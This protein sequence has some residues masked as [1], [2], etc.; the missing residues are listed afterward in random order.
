MQEQSSTTGSYDSTNPSSSQTGSQNTGS[1]HT[2]SQHKT[3]DLAEEAKR[4]ARDR[5]ISEAERGKHSASRAVSDSAKA[6]DRA[7]E[8]LNEQGQV[9]MAQ[10]TSSIASSLSDF[11]ER[12]EGRN[13]DELV[14]DIT[15]MAR[16]NPELF[17]LGGIGAG[18][19][20]SRFFK[21]SARSSRQT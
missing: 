8:T 18:L 7:A 15:N 19:I 16:R 11:A 1:E 9:T 20:L 12:L 17:I 14:H 2:E 3:S 21:A 4:A 5:A 6:L 10:T 13:T